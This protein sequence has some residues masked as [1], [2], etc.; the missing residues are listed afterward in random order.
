M[1]QSATIEKI[2]TIAPET[3]EVTLKLSESLPFIAGQYVT[4]TLSSLKELP[5][6]EQFRDF[7]I[8][9]PPEYD[10]HITIAMRNSKSVFKKQLLTGDKN[11]E[12]LIE[13]PKGIFTLPE[14]MVVGGKLCF[15]AG[16]IGVTVF[17]SMVRH[18]VFKKLPIKPTLFYY[19]RDRENATYLN[20]LEGYSDSINL[21][22]V[23]GKMTNL[24]VENYLETNPEGNIWYLAGPRG[25]V[26]TAREILTGLKV[27][28]RSIKSEEYSGY[29]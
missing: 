14:E 15:I 19:N 3:F 28:E 24:E 6:R 23:F 9:S 16:G 12:V 10:G 29:E 13:G 21:V 2:I 7:S 17:L 8:A 1:T 22:P 5:T 25:L 26:R 11:M 20:E 18:I 27:D 4:V